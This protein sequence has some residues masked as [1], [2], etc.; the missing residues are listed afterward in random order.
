MVQIK[1]LIYKILIDLYSL[2]KRREELTWAY[3][4][5][6]FPW[7]A[8]SF[9]HGRAI[10]FFH[11]RADGGRASVNE[12][13]GFPSLLQWEAHMAHTGAIDRGFYESNKP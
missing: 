12:S 4:M 10:S 11:G 5:V 13:F 2:K 6:V 8:L 3:D 9:F 1:I 7:R